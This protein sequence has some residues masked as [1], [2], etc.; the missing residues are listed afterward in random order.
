[1]RSA[2]NSLTVR[3]RIGRIVW[4]GSLV[5]LV[6]GAV[7]AT[8]PTKVHS[9]DVPPGATVCSDGA[10]FTGQ[11][12]AASSVGPMMVSEVWD[13]G[14]TMLL[15]TGNTHVFTS[16]G[17]SFSFTV[18][19]SFTVGSTV[20]LVVTNVPGSNAPLGGTEGDAATGT[21]ADCSIAVPA[22][23]PG[24]LLLLVVL[25][26][27][28]GAALLYRS[29]RTPRGAVGAGLTALAFLAAVPAR[30]RSAEASRAR[31]PTSCM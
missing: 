24:A 8:V 21:V 13:A 28:G 6:V 11:T 2:G 10:V 22:M 27:G 4:M 31:V 1:M 18:M 20:R 3:R 7:F 15:A 29:G 23:P 12:T 26:L 14:G 25:L 30:A 5:A 9:F 19:G 16:V 17:E